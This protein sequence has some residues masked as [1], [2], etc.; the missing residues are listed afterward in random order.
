MKRAAVVF[1]LGVLIVLGFQ[2]ADARHRTDLLSVRID[3]E[4][5]EPEQD[6]LVAFSVD[7]TSS[8]V[9][10]L[11]GG[12]DV[13]NG[14]FSVESVTC[15]NCAPGC[16]DG[17]QR[18]VQIDLEATEALPPGY[19]V[20][21]LTSANYS[22]TDVLYSTR[23]GLASGAELLITIEGDVLE[24]GEWFNVYFNICDSEPETW[25][26][27]CASSSAMKD[28]IINEWADAGTDIDYIELDNKGGSSVSLT[29]NLQV[30]YNTTT[31][32]VS[33]YMLSSNND[34]ST[35]WVDLP[36]TVAAGEKVILV[37]S[38]IEQA[39]INTIRGWDSGAACVLIRTNQTTLIG[40][41][42]RLDETQAYLQ[43]GAWRWSHTPELPTSL[44]STYSGL[45]STFVY[46]T[47]P[48]TDETR[49]YSGIAS[50]ARRTPGAANGNP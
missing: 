9:T 24:C 10:I 43:E 45:R 39:D 36:Y 44:S 27:S 33:Q 32:T 50:S 18:Q 2:P 26:S 28:L 1:G 35:D 41:G 47:D 25:Q 40:S 22:V 48:T 42:D 20:A 6:Y 14:S 17:A 8:M 34:P 31:V 38:D 21:E 16:I 4:P 29:A 13:I 37:D 23:A 46:E 11:N 15:L 30:V 7:P 12:R 3:I 5:V 49:W 19:A